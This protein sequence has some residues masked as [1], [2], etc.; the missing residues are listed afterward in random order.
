MGGLRTVFAALLGL[1][2]LAPPGRADPLLREFAV[3]AGRMTAQVEH[4]WL[5][6]Q[7]AG[8][9]MAA[10][11]GLVALVAALALPDDAPQVTLWRTTA[12]IATRA[13]LERA[14]FRND[15][16]ARDRAADLVNHCRALVLPG[17]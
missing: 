14:T 3:C 16:A 1:I 9:A 11:D 13:L 6:M 7:D 17:T 10:R 4:D 2:L 15:A 5:M 12:R 8:A